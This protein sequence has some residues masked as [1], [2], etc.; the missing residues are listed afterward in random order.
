[1]G[2]DKHG[3]LQEQAH[4]VLWSIPMRHP[5]DEDLIITVLNIG[6]FEPLAQ[7][8][9]TESDRVT[10]EKEMI[11]VGASCLESLADVLTIEFDKG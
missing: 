7:L 10:Y 11:V 1:L 8:V 2:I 4:R 5:F 6:T 9:P 3:R